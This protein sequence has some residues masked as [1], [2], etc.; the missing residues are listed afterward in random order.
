MMHV[1]KV[2]KEVAMSA[3]RLRIGMIGCGDVGE[4]AARGIQDAEHAEPPA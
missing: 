3:E 2:E 4:R 1:E